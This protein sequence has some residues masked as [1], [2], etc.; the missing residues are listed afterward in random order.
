MRTLQK[1]LGVGVAVALLGLN[2]ALA[3]VVK[4]DSLKKPL[5]FSIDIGDDSVN[6]PDISFDTG[7]NGGD[8]GDEA[9]TTCAMT[10]GGVASNMM[11]QQPLITV[12]RPE[13]WSNAPRSTL[14]AMDPIPQSSRNTA[15]GRRRAPPTATPLLPIDPELPLPPIVPDPDPEDPD[16]PPVIPPPPPPPTIPPPPPTDP[17][18]MDVP[19]PATLLIVGLGV[20]AIAVARR[21]GIARR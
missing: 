18:S 6:L 15:P 14:A 7:V 20:G 3:D 2:A 13:Q 11:L 12:P 5:P 16:P 17:P 21:R 10:P 1:I 4:P 19:E 8:G 9:Q